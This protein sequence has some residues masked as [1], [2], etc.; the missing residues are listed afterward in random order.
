MDAGIIFRDA[1]E[2]ASPTVLVRK[3]DVTVRYCSDL[4]NINE[5]AIKDRD[6]LPKISECIDDL[7]E[8]KYFYCLDMA[9]GFYQINMEVED[10]DKAAFVTSYGQ[11]VFNRMP[12]SLSNA[13]GTFCSA[14]GLVLKGLSWESVVSFLD[15][16]VILEMGLRIT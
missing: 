4:R 9:N 3:R 2:W 6:P 7:A 15:D 8:W 10:R 13:P 16:I 5:V 1:S 11:F 14:L 12:F